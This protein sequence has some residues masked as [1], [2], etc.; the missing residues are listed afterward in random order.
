VTPECRDGRTDYVQTLHNTDAG[1]P[2][3]NKP[4]K[5]P[6]ALTLDEGQIMRTPWATGM[7]AT[8]IEEPARLVPTLTGA[9]LGYGGWVLSRSCNDTGR[10]TMLFEFERQA[11]VDI[12]TVLAAAG[13]ELSQGDHKWFTELCQCT[14]D[15]RR[16]CGTDIASIEL[17]IQTLPAKKVNASQTS[18]AM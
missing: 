3:T 5:M 15:T 4:V 9:I 10:V 2:G 13:V 16:G 14:R 8:S 6:S 17:E 18:W 1:L 7:K 11:C 12:Y